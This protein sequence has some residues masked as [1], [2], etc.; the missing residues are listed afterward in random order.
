M[1]GGAYFIGE[2]HSSHLRYTGVDSGLRKKPENIMSG[3]MMSGA[4][5]RATATSGKMHA[6]KR[7]NEL[8]LRPR[9]MIVRMADPKRA[10]S[11]RNPTDQ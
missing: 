3:M 10:P 4:A 6:R 5:R 1:E 7:P 2:S 8:E 9:R 11:L